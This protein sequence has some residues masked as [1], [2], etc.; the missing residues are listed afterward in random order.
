MSSLEQSFLNLVREALKEPTLSLTQALENPLARALME[1]V[2]GSLAREEESRNAEEIAKVQPPITSAENPSKAIMRAA[3]E[4]TFDMAELRPD[5]AERDTLLDRSDLVT[6]AGERR[7]RL[8]DTARADILTTVWENGDFRTMLDKA[9][10]A[11]SEEHESMGKD[12]VRLISAWLRCFLTKQS[13]DL[14]SAPPR[15]LKAALAARERLRLVE[16]L[17]PTVPS[18]SELANRVGQAE[19]LEPLRVLIGAEGGW[20]GSPHM[21]N[22][23]G[24]IDELKQLRGFVGE[25]SSH[26][27]FESVSRFARR[28]TQS[29]TGRE[30]PGLSIIEAGGGLGK[31]ALVAKFVLDHALGQSRQFPFA[32]LDFDRA[33]L[34]PER[35]LQIL[36]EITRQM[37][38]QYPK[39]REDFSELVSDIRAE[40]A[41]STRESPTNRATIRDPFA[42]FVEML[43]RHATFGERP[44][45]LVLD[46]LE[47]VQWSPKAIGKLASL[48]E[49]F[50]D[51][52][53]DEL[54]V[55]ACGRADIPELR[56][57]YREEAPP[58]HLKLAPLLSNEALEMA[59]KLGRRGLGDAWK[60]GWSEAIATGKAKS[61]V[62]RLLLGWIGVADNIRREPLSVRVAVDFVIRTN[63]TDRQGVVDEIISAGADPNDDFVARL[64]EKRI[65]N[66]IRDSDAGRLA[67]PGLV[68]RRLTAEI[69]R[70]VLAELCGMSPDSAERA[71]C[72][73]GREIW[74]VDQDGDALKHRADLRARTL[75]L[76]RRKDEAKFNNVARA[77]VAYYEK[78]R[79]RSSEDRIEWLYHRLL[80][81]NSIEREATPEDLLI[82]ARS[83][84]D[85]EPGSAAA[86]FIVSRTASKR[87]APSRIRHL[88]PMDALLHLKTVDP[89]VFGLDDRS[90]D[91]VILQ[92][93]DQL[94]EEQEVG[95]LLPWARALWI[96][97]GAWE[98]LKGETFLEDGALLR[99]ELFWMARVT[100]SSDPQTR[101][102]HL[103]QVMHASSRNLSNGEHHGFR[104]MVQAMALARLLGAAVYHDLDD[105]ILNVLVSMKPNPAPSTQAALRTAIIF[106]GVCRDRALKLWL[107]TRRRGRSERVRTPTVSYAELRAMSLLVPDMRK[108]FG[109]VSEEENP[110]CITNYQ[111]VSS[112]TR[113]LDEMNGLISE[114][115]TNIGAGLA[116]VFACRQEDWIVPLAYAAVRATGGRLPTEAVQRLAGYSTHELEQRGSEQGSRNSIDLVAAMRIAD[117]AG[118]LPGFAQLVLQHCPPSSASDSLRALIH[119]QENWITAIAA[120]VAS[121][122]L[123]TQVQSAISEPKEEPPAP[124]P[125]IDK[126]DLQRGRWGGLAHRDG[127]LLRAVL[128]SV[129][130]DIFYFNLIVEST[131]GSPLVAPVHFH[132]HDTYDRNAISIRR[133]IEGSYA[134][135]HDL[136]AYGVF[137]VGAQVR[138]GKGNW[139]SLELDLASL[140]DLPERFLS[141]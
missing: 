43:R 126:D 70:D 94:G 25:L 81:G 80:A 111:V 123:A 120:F 106:G 47:V 10:A 118:D 128:E 101:W 96:K 21:D 50:R 36:L 68:I 38:L 91:S 19:L 41:G 54:R 133:I 4:D 87:L 2:R 71:F 33:T 52:G 53:L 22:F 108:L 67:W 63:P 129:E 103:E 137:V 88:R 32:Y 98:R 7:L 62:A 39:A 104:G 82:L 130:R 57:V 95:D 83:E 77:A 135:L 1:T 37:A 138:D 3:I 85:F 56:A 139:I 117:E 27:A 42:R 102:A 78:H 122:P 92:L 46:T 131:D 127:R 134:Q 97:T 136:N 89:G 64:Y 28:T 90:L 23:V 58:I 74:M 29:L 116:A 112:F 24:R 17:S 93:S 105:Q 66:H 119:C 48:V 140:S 86:S 121:A 79:E 51:K 13:F 124:G 8:T 65:L 113:A 5:K 110:G 20:A 26:G 100:A 18:C 6:L 11:D 49:Q 69:A 15:E 16:K 14:S 59:E 9:L 34:D 73:L 61:P 84:A 30:G 132:L 35:P 45:L 55:V 76:M 107:Y 75:P 141:R 12:P 99:L 72:A 40:L 115:A 31:S 60:P 125:V 44:F 109:Y 114:G